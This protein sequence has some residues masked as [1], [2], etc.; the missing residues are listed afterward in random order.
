MTPRELTEKMVAWAQA[1]QID[2]EPAVQVLIDTVLGIQREVIS[3]ETATSGVGESIG[4]RPTLGPIPVPK[5]PQR[6][7][8]VITKHNGFIP[9]ENAIICLGPW[10]GAI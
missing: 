8:G 4:A 7:S 2:G 3:D 5:Q 1:C 6:V 9:S 10:S